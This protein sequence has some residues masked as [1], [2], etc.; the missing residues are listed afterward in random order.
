MI[1]HA[2][3]AERVYG[4]D[5]PENW[6]MNIMRY[7]PILVSITLPLL[8]YHYQN[9]ETK[10]KGIIKMFFDVIYKDIPDSDFI[11]PEKEKEYRKMRIK[12]TDKV[13]GDG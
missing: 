10:L 12:I 3:F 11:K 5:F 9:I 8:F 13:V 4:G 6:Y 2:L 1:L 7:I